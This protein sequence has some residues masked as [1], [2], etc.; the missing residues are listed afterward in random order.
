MNLAALAQDNRKLL[1]R[2][3]TFP[4]PF[5]SHLHYKFGVADPLRRD[6]Q[7]QILGENVEIEQFYDLGSLIG[8]G[9]F[10]TVKEST[11]AS[12]FQTYAVKVVQKS[13]LKGNGG[14]PG[15][16]VEL[17][18]GK[19]GAVK[20]AT[21]LNDEN[22]RD[23]VELLMNQRHRFTVTIERVFEDTKCYYLVMQK[24]TGGDLRKHIDALQQEKQ[25]FDEDKLKG[26]VR[27]LGDALRFLHSMARVHRD[28]KPENILYETE[29]GEV[30]KLADFDM[31]C[32]CEES[33]E[34]VIGSSIVGTLGYLP[35][36]VLSLKHYSRQ[37]DMF[38]LGVL[39]HFCETLSPPKEMVSSRDVTAWCEATQKRLAD[40]SGA[41]AESPGQL[42]AA[43]GALLSPAPTLRP[44]NM[45]MF[46]DC[47]W[48]GGAGTS[49]KKASLKS[50]KAIR[51]DAIH[52][53]LKQFDDA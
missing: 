13:I 43:I 28:V 37:S 6:R 17:I 41:C 35:P 23:I 22:F 5:M 49:Q 21:E 52:R 19:V 9:G 33:E 2:S 53:L 42:R 29:A 26:I 46:L 34:F 15:K 14:K 45:E 40:G 12:T 38:A 31:C 30:V 39:M 32:R 20:D 48:L 47:A 11:N 44:A 50:K 8:S 51:P 10:G 4:D 7:I 27:M 16:T 36:E 18:E 25:Q 3:K 1:V 24:C